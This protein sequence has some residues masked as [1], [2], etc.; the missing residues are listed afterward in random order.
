MIR[1]PETPR[2]AVHALFV[3]FVALPLACSSGPEP[4]VKGP[5][6]SPSGSP[7]APSLPYPLTPWT[8]DLDCEQ[9]MGLGLGDIN[10]DGFVDVVVS[11][12]NDVAEQPV[13]VY[14]N[15]KT[16]HFPKAP[17][18]KS[19][20]VGY[21]TGLSLGDVDKDGFLDLAVSLG[22]PA[23]APDKG[24]VVLFY[25]KGG[26]LEKTP[27]YRSSSLLTSVACALGDV[28]GDGDLDLATSVAR[29]PAAETR[30]YVF[31]NINGRVT[32]APAWQTKE[33]VVSTAVLF[34]DLD[35]DGLLD[36]TLGGPSL[37]A[38]F[39][40][41][42]SVGT[43]GVAVSD[44]PGWIVPGKKNLS[45]A[46]DAGRMGSGTALLASWTDYVSGNGVV[47]AKG[48]PCP[49][50]LDAGACQLT[51]SSQSRF[52]GY[53]PTRAPAMEPEPFW[54]SD[55]TG[56]GGGESLADLN[57]DGLLDLVAGRWGPS[58]VGLGAPLT[59]Y[60][61]TPGSLQTTPAWT[62]STCSAVEVVAAADLDN[63]RWVAAEETFTFSGPSAVV[64]LAHRPVARIDQILKNGAPLSPKQY[65]SVPGGDWISFTERLSAA[66]T[67]RVQY[68]YSPT[69]DL[70]VVNF[71][72]AN[73]I[74]Y[75]ETAQAGGAAR[76]HAGAQP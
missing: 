9:A 21:H 72:S 53:R 12:G 73:M 2:S 39:G 70:V 45:L 65:A 20:E 40:R 47:D 76:P 43:G 1:A 3:F 29:T 52:A 60:L 67:V 8:F 42:L 15:D 33:P 32:G 68:S 26:Q 24:G 34:A 19:D 23:T 50:A 66:D 30:A 51:T 38:Y 71:G 58:T 64:T 75:R 35:R 7:V 27:S 61:G 69:P 16:G 48:P 41:L 11:N 18:W 46:L 31:E 49:E 25:N 10:G 37:Q 55:A 13:Y 74:F 22:P 57:G 28:D 17:S 14:Y 56:W 44:T 63:K 59:I 6:T 54:R 36:L 4:P 62:S 5:G